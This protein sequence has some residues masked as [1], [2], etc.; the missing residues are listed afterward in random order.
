MGNSI[1]S[2]KQREDIREA[3][4]EASKAGQGLEKITGGPI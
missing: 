3:E 4:R 2:K 1:Q